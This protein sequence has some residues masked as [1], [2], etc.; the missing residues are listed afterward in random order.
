MMFEAAP[1][2]YEHSAR[3]RIESLLD[4]SSFREFLGPEQRVISPHLQ[5][6]NLP[7]AFDDGMIVGSGRLEGRSVLLAAQE[8]RFMGGAIGEVHGAKLVGLLRAAVA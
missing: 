6:F 3:A 2:W 4:P 5:A 1:S 8:G 7:P